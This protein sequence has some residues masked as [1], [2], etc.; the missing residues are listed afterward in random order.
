MD[1]INTGKTEEINDDTDVLSLDETTLDEILS[2]D[3]IDNDKFLDTIKTL[4]SSNSE[5][6]ES[7]IFLKDIKITKEAKIDEEKPTD[8]APNLQQEVSEEKPAEEPVAKEPDKTEKPLLV[9]DEVI[10]QKVNEFREKNKDAQNLDQMAQDFKQILNGVKGDQFSERAF[11]NY[12]NS[13]IYIKSLKSPFDPD[14]KP[15]KKVVESPDYIEMAKKQKGDMLLKAVRTKYPDFPE[16][17][18]SDPEAKLEFERDLVAQN[19]TGILEY[20]RYLEEV[21]GKI[22]TEFD[23]HYDIVTN[24]ED[25]AKTQ[26]EADVQLFKNYLDAKGLTLAD[27]GVPDLTFDDKYYNKFLFDNILQPNGK[28]NENVIAWYQK[29]TPVIKPFMVTNQLKDYFDVAIE[30]KI[31]ERAR[32]EGFKLGQNAIIEPSLSESPGMG[33]RKPSDESSVFDNDEAKIEDIDSALTKIKNSVLGK[34]K[35]K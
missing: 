14:W 13:Q 26:I 7:K 9:T 3:D 16:N 12:I 33:Y 34:G 28:P 6:V 29:N 15:E 24:W 8:E 27:I 1:Q 17:G 10:Q 35:R 19:P 31:K 22:D 4:S 2:R 25:R 32:A 30:D 5:N 11:K 20:G 23:R 21:S 18:L